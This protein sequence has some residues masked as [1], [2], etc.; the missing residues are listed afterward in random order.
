MLYIYI[1]VCCLTHFTDV[2][3]LPVA[4]DVGPRAN[5]HAATG[6]LAIRSRLVPI[7]PRV[8]GSA[9]TP[10]PRVSTRLTR[11]RTAIGAVTAR[12]VAMKAN[13]QE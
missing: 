3:H 6:T 7:V 12:G 4:V 8:D 1:Q 11:R 10:R 2:L 13:P 5:D 9:V